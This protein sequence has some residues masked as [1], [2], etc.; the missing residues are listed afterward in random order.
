[1]I[2]AIK[3]VCALMS[4]SAVALLSGCSPTE[5]PLESAAV[6]AGHEV[7][8]G[9]VVM[10][11][12]T[13]GQY[14]RIIAH[15]F[16]STIQLGGRFEPDVRVGGLLEV[17]T[18]R[19]SVTPSGFEQYDL[20]GRN[21]AAQ[22]L[23]EKNRPIL[24]PCKPASIDAPDDA[25]AAQFLSRVGRLLYRRPLT[26]AE[27]TVQVQKAALATETLADFYVG[28]ELSLASMFVLPPFLFRQEIAEPDPNH[29]GM[30][31]LD[32]YS[33][34]ARLSFFLWDAAPDPDLLDA[35]ANGDL[36]T[37]KGLER[38]VDRMLGSPRIKEGVQA[39]FADM[40]EFDS[41]ETLSKDTTL[42]PKFT[43]RVVDDAAEQ[44]LRTITQHLLVENGDYRDLFTTPRTFLTPLLGSLYR[45]P[46]ASP[47]GWA[48]Y[49]YRSDDVQAGILTHLSFV[50]LHSHP[51]RTSPTLRG[52]ALR[53]VLLCQKVPDPPGNVDFN[54]VQD[55]ANPDFKTVRQRLDA[56]ASEPMCVGCH[57]ITDPLGLALENFSTIGGFRTSENG[58]PID[59]SGSLDGVAFA[60]AAGLGRAVH[61]N[62]ATAS[63]LVNR[64]YSYGVGREPTR[65]EVAWL[66]DY[67]EMRFQD[68]GYTLP[69]LLRTIAMSDTFYRVVPS[70]QEARL[71]QA[72]GSTQLRPV[73]K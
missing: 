54:I 48:P 59:T 9:P 23:G 38:Q 49:E 11:R 30:M 45:V 64:I 15:V 32:G 56:H 18:G 10:R 63:C 1:M 57:K 61:D 35:A 55:T 41:F 22:V 27:L 37:P 46:V 66:K 36:H 3:F 71:I 25:C 51:G 52:K 31:R 43:F 70:D 68:A 5:A 42:Y 13:E 39:F 20:M 2:V 60:D 14:D 19:V 26:D 16:G 7:A 53:E 12:I 72:A 6:G 24:M 8:G 34:A 28:L 73:E 65:S 29:P 58:A 33:K 4:M 17:G 40:L 69:Q 62:P 50:A 21:I 67:V 47:D 44:T